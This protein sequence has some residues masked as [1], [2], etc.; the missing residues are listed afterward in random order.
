M[1]YAPKFELFILILICNAPHIDANTPFADELD[2][3]LLAT[4]T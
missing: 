3:L 1:K 2:L 4:T